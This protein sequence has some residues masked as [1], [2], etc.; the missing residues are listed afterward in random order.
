[1]QHV[2]MDVGVAGGKVLPAWNKTTNTVSSIVGRR[3]G[4]QSQD[5][6]ILRHSQSLLRHRRALKNPPAAHT[7]CS[8]TALAW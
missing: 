1:M 3:R 8:T 4:I 7:T 5:V 6:N 2:C